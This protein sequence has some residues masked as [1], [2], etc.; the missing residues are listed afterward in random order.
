MKREF[1]R[2]LDRPINIF[3]LKG[4]W[5]RYFFYFAGVFLVLAF[6][7]GGIVGVGM[8]F[9]IFLAG[10]IGSF[11]ACLVLQDRLPSRRIAKVRLRSKMRSRVVRRETL[12]RILLEDPRDRT[13]VYHDNPS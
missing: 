12:C 1:Y 9:A 8:G 6:L 2:S 3:G 7:V 10:A 5:V 4:E 13:M 11:F